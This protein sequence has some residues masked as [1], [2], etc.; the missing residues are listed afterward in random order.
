MLLKMVLNR[1]KIWFSISGLIA[2]DQLIK[3][4]INDQFLDAKAAIIKPFLYFEPMFN[5][6]Y[7]WI[8]SML[9]L[10][11]SKWVHVSLTALICVL[12]I[13]FF[14]F[15]SKKEKTN[16]VINTSF[17]FLLAG[18]VCSLIDKVLWDGSLD[19]ILLD[20]CFT[21][22]L[23]DVYINV[24]NGILIFLLIFRNKTIGIFED[25]T[26]FRDFLRFVLRKE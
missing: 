4:I 1:L 6:H 20:G 22:D 9:R 14:I 7:S 24:F 19:Y 5:R 12:I 15:L 8:N 26:L 23:K 17:A 2:L 13:L 21:F 3:L 16:G 11:V 18:A 25:K 10:A